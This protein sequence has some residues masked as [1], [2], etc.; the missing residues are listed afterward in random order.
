MAYNYFP[1]NYQMPAYYPTQSNAYPTQQSVGTN[2][3]ALIWVQGE[4][5]AKSYMVAPNQTVVL[6]DSEQDAVYIKSADASGMPSIKVLDYTIR[7]NGAQKAEI[8]AQ[9]DFATKDDVELL[10][11]EINALKAKFEVRKDGKK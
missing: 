3:N 5:G 10:K 8:L 2:T 1:Q 9:K 7:D 4:A 11:K 6:W